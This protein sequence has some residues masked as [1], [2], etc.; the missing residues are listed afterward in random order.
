MSPHAPVRRPSIRCPVRLGAVFD[1]ADLPFSRDAQD[2][3]EIGGL[4]V[5]MNRDDGAGS[6]RD[7]RF[8]LRRI[9]RERARVN[10]HQHRRRA[11]QLDG[12][13]RGDGR[14]RHGDDLVARPHAAGAQ[15]QVK[16][17]SAAAHADAKAHADIVRE[18]ALEGG[19]FLAQDVA[20]LFE[21]ARDG[22]VN[23]GLV[24]DR[25]GRV[26][27]LEESCRAVPVTSFPSPRWRGEGARSISG[28][29][30]SCR[31]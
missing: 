5:E 28:L 31:L 23:L 4:A 18:L 26:D 9:E 8:Q 29:W 12:R 13:D 17:L 24:A 11:A 2:R 3:F 25:I 21:H 27:W 1:H 19:G 14:V 16:R 22:L 10:V 30:K 15:R 7:G 20:A 6:R